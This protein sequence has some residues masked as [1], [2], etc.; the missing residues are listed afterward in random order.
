MR[1]IKF[2][3]WSIAENKMLYDVQDVYD[4]NTEP[5]IANS[6]GDVLLAT[7]E[8]IVEQFTG[9]IDKNGKEIY[10]GDIVRITDLTSFEMFGDGPL[11]RAYTRNWIVE[12]GQV[13]F[14]TRFYDDKC[15]YGREIVFDMAT[16]GV[17]YEIIGNIHEKEQGK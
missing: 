6:F 13:G 3:A 5:Y 15:G 16:E 14:K 11:M 17:E 7:D 12:W 4:W 10:E 2:R 9:L 1:P 8:F